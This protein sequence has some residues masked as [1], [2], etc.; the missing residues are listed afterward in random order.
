MLEPELSQ[1]EELLWAQRS[2][3]PCA[4]KMV[5]K[6][7]LITLMGIAIIFAA[8]QIL[9]NEPP[10]TSIAIAV[11][12]LILLIVFVLALIELRKAAHN[13][14]SS[15]YAATTARIISVFI[16]KE[17]AEKS[18]NSLP[19]NAIYKISDFGKSATR[20]VTLKL[21]QKRI[22]TAF[23]ELTAVPHAKELVTLIKDRAPNVTQ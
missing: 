14:Q 20:T 21:S 4:Q 23:A 10:R 7:Y 2:D 12:I 5:L 8:T 9:S 18:V 19:Y 15:A 11:F 16:D 1:G 3:V 6:N 13:A 17:T 22:S